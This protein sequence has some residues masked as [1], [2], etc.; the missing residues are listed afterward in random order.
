MKLIIHH[1]VVCPAFP[2]HNVVRIHYRD[3]RHRRNS[4]F[5]RHRRRRHRRRRHRRRRRP[6]LRRRQGQLVLGSAFVRVSR[7]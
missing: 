7:F 6:R 2:S 5:R 1:P 3:H 4:R